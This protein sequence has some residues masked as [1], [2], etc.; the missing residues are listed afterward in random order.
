MLRTVL[1]QTYNRAIAVDTSGYGNNGIPILVTAA[2]PGFSF[3]QPGSRINVQPSLSLSNLASINAEVAFTLAPQGAPK[4]Y[5]LAE[6]FE[7]FAL[8]VNPDLSFSGTIFDAS[9]NWAG[10]TSAPGSVTS[11]KLHRAGLQADGFN[12]VRVL[13]DGNVI[14][15][16]YSVNGKV[17]SVGS[18]GL[19]I[20]HWPNPPNQYTFEGTI[21][22]VLLQK[23][24]PLSPL[25][26]L[27]PCCFDRRAL[28]DWFKSVARRG[29]SA[30]NILKASAALQAAARAAVL[31]MRGDDETR[32]TTFQ[33]LI[34]GLQL[35]LKR[36][37][38][39]AL[40][41]VLKQLQR[42]ADSTLDSATRAQLGSQV[43]TALAQFG[44]DF[45]DWCRLAAI[46]CLGPR[47]HGGKEGSNG[48]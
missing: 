46:L 11:G 17:R 20:G 25:E 40:E 33:S 45:N 1:H 34:N 10:A 6:G 12:M 44:L 3:L 13:L 41:S 43:Q 15:A 4:R 36:R 28:S 9:S 37:D 47:C 32:T 21:F 19:A 38:C 39:A 18:L 5:N 2:S 30:A 23:Y 22:E 26:V 7:S 27:D 16:N 48:N 14:G 42:F 8:Y 35:A 29:V 24:D 31:A